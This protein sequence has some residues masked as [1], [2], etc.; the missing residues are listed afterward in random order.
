MD[1]PK[2]RTGK[3][4]VLNKY[5]YNMQNLTV[6]SAQKRF[7]LSRTENRLAENDFLFGAYFP[8]ERFIA[9]RSLSFPV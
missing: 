9:L 4:F 6:F 7:F 5:S 3:M 1:K 2:K 8:A